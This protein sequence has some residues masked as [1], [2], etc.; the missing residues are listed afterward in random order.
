MKKTAI[1]F[2][3]LAIL[4]LIFRLHTLVNVMKQSDEK[5][6]SGF[7]KT[8]A[9]IGIQDT[10]AGGGW[11]WK[12]EIFTWTGIK[13]TGPD[14]A[15]WDDSTYVYDIAG[16]DSVGI[17]IEFGSAGLDSVCIAYSLTGAGGSY[18]NI[19]DTI[20]DSKAQI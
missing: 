13:L 2:L 4:L 14:S 19:S 11:M 7:N 8:N 15:A 6:G 3:V 17:P 5:I 20:I 18:T 10:T 12:S 1:P 16:I 9:M